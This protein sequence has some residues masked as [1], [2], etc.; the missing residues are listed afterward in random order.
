MHFSGGGQ[1]PRPWRRD[2]GPEVQA[3]S[4]T[5]SSRVRTRMRI[6]P[7]SPP[8]PPRNPHARARSA[9][10]SKHALHIQMMQGTLL[11]W[12]GQRGAQGPR[13]RGRAGAGGKKSWPKVQQPALLQVLMVPEERLAVPWGLGRGGVLA[14]VTRWFGWPSSCQTVCE[15]DDPQT[16][17][18][19]RKDPKAAPR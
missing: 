3:R 8:T 6:E 7:L 12:G 15:K 4:S 19:M 2:Q 13:A 5:T 16:P 18:H 9:S 14:R 17:T 11:A 10:H 1:P